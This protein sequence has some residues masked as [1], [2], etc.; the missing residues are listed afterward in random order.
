M[1]P[2]TVFQVRTAYD[3]HAM[4]QPGKP[5][6][7][8]NSPVRAENPMTRV[9]FIHAAWIVAMTVGLTGASCA[10]HQPEGPEAK[11]AATPTQL[12]QQP[13]SPVREP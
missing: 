12:H 3:R 7:S 9:R 8:V 6:Q 13:A 4:Y 2:W 10:I 11:P 1:I 5:Q